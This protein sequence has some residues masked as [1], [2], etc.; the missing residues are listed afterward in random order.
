[1]GYAEK[2]HTAQSL[3]HLQAAW[4]EI[5]L[6]AQAEQ[7]LVGP[8]Q[9]S[10]EMWK[11]AGK[12]IDNV[13]ASFPSVNNELL[14]AWWSPAD[15]SLY[16]SASEATTNALQTSR[17]SSAEVPT[18][19][20]QLVPVITDTL[21]ASQAA[22]AAL[23]Q[24]VKLFNEWVAANP[25]ATP[26]QIKAQNALFA[27]QARPAV[28]AA[29]EALNRLAEWYKYTGSAVVSAAQGLQ[30]VGP[31]SGNSIA[32]GGGP[33][34]AQT[35]P[36]G[37]PNGA[38]MG[39]GGPEGGMD[40]AGMGAGAGGGGG[41]MEGA[42]GEAGAGAP[43]GGAAGGMPG[44][45]GG[46][47]LAGMPTLPATAPPPQFGLPTAPP[48]NIPPNIPPGVVPPIGTVPVR[49]VPV[50]GPTG[51]SKGGAKFGGGGLGGLKT[52]GIPAAKTGTGLN[53]PGAGERQIPRAGEQLSQPQNLS[54]GRP[55]ATG[56]G[57]G[58]GLAG[59]ASPGTGAGGVP[60]MM[61]PGAMGA[62]GPGNRGGKPGAG[63]I[64]PVGR[65][66]DR[67]HGETPGVPVGLRGKAGKDLPGAF[68][69]VPAG[70]R[71]RQ[72]K[73]QPADTLQLLDEELWKVEGAETVATPTPPRRL[74]T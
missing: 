62:A 29:G 27:A 9:T 25:L 17:N 54:G 18:L 56:G 53:L 59:T 60:P 65:K 13:L 40:Q 32:G 35:G 37:T 31:G 72:E 74:A 39:A 4:V 26:E 28:V 69:A 42:G 41:G 57:A 33:R 67:K 51:A 43:P 71:R 6:Y 47:G 48:P 10:Q 11:S 63:T 66:R 46:T 16:E 7:N 5:D 52:G 38:D 45:T 61:P 15:S 58:T 73:N 64:R 8:L 14:A 22:K 21:P 30:W 3:E 23:D 36:G 24:A 50:G 20:A 44:G 49:G 68:P 1:M 12:A 34:T 55:P 70:T 19:L 2:A